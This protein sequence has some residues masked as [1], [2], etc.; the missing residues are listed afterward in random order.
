M[1]QKC[2]FCG[3]EIG[4][5]SRENIVCGG[6][7]QPSCSECHLL[8]RN[9]SQKERGER[10]LATG[11]AVE[12]ERIMANLEKE[13]QREKEDRER[14]ESPPGDPDGQDLPALRGSHGTVWA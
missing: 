6:V 3:R 2:V 7:E 11:R 8:L 13:E 10:A 9:L 12:P 1:A 5:F 4:L 14:Q